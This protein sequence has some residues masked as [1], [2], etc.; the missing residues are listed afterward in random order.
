MSLSDERIREKR[1]FV[2]TRKVDIGACE[3]DGCGRVY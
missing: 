1:A 2:D 3:Y